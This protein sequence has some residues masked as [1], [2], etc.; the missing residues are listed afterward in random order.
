[1]DATPPDPSPRFDVIADGGLDPLPGLANDVPVAPFALHF[2]DETFS[3][4]ELPR[5]AFFERLRSGGPH[6]STSQ[7]SPEQYAALLRE[8]T[9]PTLA[10]TISS[11]LSSSLNAADQARSAAPAPV[12]L[13]DAGTLSGAQAF[14]VHAA[15]TARARGEDVESAIRTMREVHEETELYFTIDTLEYLRKGGRIG[16]VQATLGRMLN[17]KPVV[18]VDKA[19]G[20]YTSVGRARTWGKALDA[21]VERV[22]VRYGAGTPLRVALL[23]GETRDDAEA[24]L[25]RLRRQHEIV[26]HGTAPVGVALAVHTGPKAVGLAVAPGPWPW[27]RD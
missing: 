1:M 10:V 8:A 13:H 19:T 7:P 23:H 20:A 11:G 24:V 18:T 3:A 2:G 25:E 5:E 22:G 6:P 12:H 16:A 14:Q 17:L 26:W 4:D 9:R 21:I 27:E 15:M